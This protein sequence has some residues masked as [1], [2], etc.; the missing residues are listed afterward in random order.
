MSNE[1]QLAKWR[2]AGEKAWMEDLSVDMRAHPKKMYAAGYLRAK[3]ETEQA[4]KD[5]RK[6][7]LEDAIAICEARINQYNAPVSE[8]L[9]SKW[10]ALMVKIEGVG[11]SDCK[12]KIKELLND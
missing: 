2:E 7:A 9:L 5:A 1:T 6:Q 11:A 8:G 4:I 12:E 3:Q 10:Q